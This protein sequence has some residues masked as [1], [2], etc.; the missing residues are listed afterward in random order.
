MAH[1]KQHWVPS[2]Y[3]GAWCDPD[4]PPKYDPYV[5]IFP[6]DGGNGQRK[7]P[8]NIFAETDF[9]TIHLPDGARDLSLE[10]GLA[11]FET[12]FSRIRE[13]RIDKR[14]PLSAE[15]KRVNKSLD[16][17]D[18]TRGNEIIRDWEIAGTIQPK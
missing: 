1:R 2:S 12:R 9:Y 4:R 15:D 10:H 3:L 14:Q 8:R 18:W 5:W 13:T 6:K 17:R 16:I 7:S 11:T